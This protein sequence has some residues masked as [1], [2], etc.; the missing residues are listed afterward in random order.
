MPCGGFSTVLP[1]QNCPTPTTVAEFYAAKTSQRL[2]AEWIPAYWLPYS[3]DLKSVDFSICSIL[4]PKGQATPHANLAA[5]HL[6]VAAEWDW[7]AA[8]QIRKTCLTFHCHQEAT[9]RKIMFELNK[10]L[11]NSPTHINKYFLGPT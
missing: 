5:L 4:Q 6:F 1:R 7:L 11:A 8:V 9:A 3:P 10:W 2:L